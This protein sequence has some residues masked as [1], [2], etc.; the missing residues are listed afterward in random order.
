MAKTVKSED[1]ARLYKYLMTM[2]GYR[3]VLGIRHAY[4][5]I[6][7]KDRDKILEFDMT[8]PSEFLHNVDAVVG[9]L[10]RANFASLSYEENFTDNGVI[11]ITTGDVEETS[12]D[13][14]TNGIHIEPNGS[15]FADLNFSSVSIVAEVAR[16]F[17][18]W[19][20]L[21]DNTY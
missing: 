4:L 8:N 19:W 11:W 16:F 14:D 15:E 5:N 1:I 2:K 13:R 18:E 20:N 21:L 3:D 10:V 9:Q 6:Y 7:D 17:K 12:F